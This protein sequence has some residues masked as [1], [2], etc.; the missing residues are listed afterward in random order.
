[1]VPY[2]FL[3]PPWPYV[4]ARRHFVVLDRVSAVPNWRNIE[5]GVLVRGGPAPQRAAEHLRALVGNGTLERVG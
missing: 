4:S 1:M 5:A 2:E 3:F